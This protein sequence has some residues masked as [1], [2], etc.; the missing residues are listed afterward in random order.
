MPLE[1]LTLPHVLPALLEV[2]QVAR[3]LSA[4]PEYVRRLIRSKQ[5][6]AIRLGTR[7]RIDPVDYQAFEDAQRRA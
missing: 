1:V 2:S 5:L 6:K 7:W 4:S 3:R